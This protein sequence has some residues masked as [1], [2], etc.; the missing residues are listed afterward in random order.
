MKLRFETEDGK[1]FD[2]EAAA[3]EHERKLASS[4]EDKYNKY[5]KQTYSG[6]RL[7]EKY[8]LSTE[9]LWEVFGEDPNC[10]FGGY[11]HKP[12]LGL[13]QGTLENVIRWGVAQGGFWQW[14]GGGDF[15]L[16]KPLKVVNTG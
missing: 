8:S 16:R 6:K 13:V 2:T 4:N 1:V 3:L 7:L 14:G 12:S 9:G 5:L 11:H 10:D 15:E